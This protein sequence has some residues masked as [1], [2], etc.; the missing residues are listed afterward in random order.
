MR[1]PLGHRTGLHVGS[2]RGVADVSASRPCP[3]GCAWWEEGARGTD[4][5]FNYPGR[6]QGQARA[7]VTA[8]RRGGARPSSQPA[9]D[10]PR[11]GVRAPGTRGGRTRGSQDPWD[12]PG[13]GLAVGLLL[14]SFQVSW[15]HGRACGLNKGRICNWEGGCVH[16]PRPR[17]GELRGAAVNPSRWRVFSQ[18]DLPLGRRLRAEHVQETPPH[19]GRTRSHGLRNGVCPAPVPQRPHASTPARLTPS[20]AGPCGHARLHVGVRTRGWVGAPFKGSAR[21]A[22]PGTRSD[23]STKLGASGPAEPAGTVPS[24]P[25]LRGVCD[26]GVLCLGESHTWSRAVCSFSR[27]VCGIIHVESGTLLTPLHS[28]TSLEGGAGR[29]YRRQCLGA[30]MLGY[31]GYSR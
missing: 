25:R 8:E 11:A 22:R 27:R 15:A 31:C 3:W 10:E 23:V 20:Q 21:G 18:T 29:F 17:R 12:G 28:G 24:G 19:L 16:G 5:S 30:W 6:G 9:P 13:L 4:S 14:R 1:R 26:G 2:L 7:G